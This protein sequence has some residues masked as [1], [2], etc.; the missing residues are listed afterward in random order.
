MM[1]LILKAIPTSIPS[2]ILLCRDTARM[3]NILQATERKSLKEGALGNGERIPLVMV[4][5]AMGI[6]DSITGDMPHP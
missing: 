6:D 3:R 1:N 2:S 4:E 5:S